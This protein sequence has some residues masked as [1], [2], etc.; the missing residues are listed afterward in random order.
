MARQAPLHAGMESGAAH[1]D[2]GAF[3]QPKPVES[4]RP[5]CQ[6]P[7]TV[8]GAKIDGDIGS[9]HPHFSLFASELK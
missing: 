5:A 1:L 2:A 4:V 9:A 8:L 7:A 3:G 6:S